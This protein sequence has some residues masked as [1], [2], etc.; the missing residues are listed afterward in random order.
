MSK[1]SKCE[2]AFWGEVDK[3]QQRK[4]H[5]TPG[6]VY[7]VQEWDDSRFS[8]T[9]LAVDDEEIVIRYEDGLT[10]RIPRSH[11]ESICTLGY[12]PS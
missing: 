12:N 7:P 8:V 1:M 10:H 9:C 5:P 4:L 2:S 3:E 6:E 11:F